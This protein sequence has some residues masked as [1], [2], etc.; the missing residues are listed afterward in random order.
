MSKLGQ[1]LSGGTLPLAIKWSLSIGTLIALVMALLGWFLIE[2]QKNSYRHQTELLGQMIADQ[3]AH[4]ASEPLMADDQFN[5]ELIVNQQQ[6]NDLII[7][8]QVFDLDKNTVVSAGLQPELKLVQAALG[9]AASGAEQSGGRFWSRPDGSA[10]FFLMPV[11][12]QDTVV[13]H[14]MVSI[15]RQPLEDNLRGLI[16]ALV[17]TTTGLVILGVILAFVL[18]HRLARPIHQLVEAGEAIHRGESNRLNADMRK[19]EIGQV[20]TSFQNLAKGLEQ[21]KIVEQAFSRYLDPSIAQRILAD[22]N[23][24]DKFAGMTTEGSVLFCDIVGFTELSESLPPEQVAA[25]LNSYF[26]YFALAASSCCGTVDKFIGDCIMILFGVPEHDPKHALHAV[27]CAV[28]I[29]ELACQINLR[30]DERG[31]D[32]V[33]FRIGINSGAMLAGNLGNEERMQYTVVGDVVNVASRICDLASPDGILLTGETAEH[34][35]ID[36]FVRPTG[37]GTVQIRGRKR[38]VKPYYI[39]VD[40]FTDAALVRNNMQS[41]LADVEG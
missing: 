3:F 39:D 15:D 38:Q 37:V 2:Q 40:E 25:I 11:R 8:M 19:D 16:R 32:T 22:T 20:M 23:N 18:A 7:G 24:G 1:H 26:G 13:G 29:Q 5:L 34:P 10:I 33:Q 31:L 28:L 27:T 41:I 4:S 17:A 9:S 21:K 12:Y 6:K 14:A 30:R 35:E 36:R